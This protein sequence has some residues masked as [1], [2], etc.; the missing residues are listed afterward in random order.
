M[1]SIFHFESYF[2]SFVKARFTNDRLQERNRPKEAPKAPEKAPF[3]LPSLL[4]GKDSQSIT[5]G[6]A[7][8]AEL[9]S[10]TQRAEAERSRVSKRSLGGLASS[11]SPI[12]DFLKDGHASGH[13]E[14][15]IEH[16]KSLPP[17]QADLEIRSLDPRVSSGFSELATFVTALTT[18]LRLK[19]DFE[20][21]NAWMAVFLK[22]HADAVSLCSHRQEVEYRL[23]HE[24]LTSWTSEQQQEAQRLAG[25]VGYCRGVA[26]FLRSA[27]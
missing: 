22:I 25:L 5:S 9:D 18:R 7:D 26:G 3:F 19:R 11:T 20:L 8:S 21:V 2:F 14:A 10:L 24:A 6:T 15:L 12:T 23:L 4:G 27:R 13:F 1:L 16:L 17:A